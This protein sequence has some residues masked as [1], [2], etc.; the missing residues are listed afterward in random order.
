[1]WFWL[2]KGGPMMVPIVL[3]SIFSLAIIIER[4]FF[5]FS[6][7]RFNPQNL[8]SQVSTS[9]RKNKISE[10]VD[11]C[12]KSPFYITNILK[13]GLVYHESSREIVKENM[14]AAALYEIPQLEKNLNLLNIISQIAPLLGFLG[15]AIGLLKGFYA[16]SE[17][18]LNVGAIGQPDLALGFGQ[19]LIVTAS[20]LS[21]ALIAAIAYGYFVHKVN[22]YILEAERAAS[23][24]LEALSQRR[25]GSEV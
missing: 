22:F 14:D 24:L 5:Y 18:T 3:C 2:L 7:F 19:A 11:V 17:K 13:A 21:V 12:E 4:I 8:V 20:G 16:I 6:F 15:T 9:V 25:Y 10:A 23:E 1:M